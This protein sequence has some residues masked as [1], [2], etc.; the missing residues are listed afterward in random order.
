MRSVRRTWND[1]VANLGRIIG[2]DRYQ[3][4]AGSLSRLGSRGVRFSVQLVGRRLSTLL[5]LAPKERDTRLRI[6]LKDQ[7]RRLNQRFPHAKLSSRDKRKG[8]WTLDGTLPARQVCGFAARP[9]IQYVQVHSIS[10]RRPARTPKQPAW[11]CVWGVVAIQIEGRRNGMVDVEDRL[12]LVKAFDVQNAQR[13]LQTEWARYAKPYMNPY[14]QLVRWKLISVRDVY[15]V[16]PDNLDPRGTEVYSRL[17]SERMKDAYR[18]VPK[19]R[20][21]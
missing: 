17:R 3:L 1:H 21:V 10:G 13:R 4:S 11:F 19:V 6:A 8:S 14:G 18:W 20:G 5:P 16:G 2:L 9:E 12:V 7:L 15:A